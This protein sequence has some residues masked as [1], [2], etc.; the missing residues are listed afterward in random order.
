MLK[1]SHY[2]L[3]M[4]PRNAED[5]EADIQQGIRRGQDGFVL[6][7][8]A[9]STD[10]NYKA[11]ADLLF[12]AADKTSFG[13][14]WSLDM[15]GTLTAADIGAMVLGY[16]KRWSYIDIDDRPFVSTFRGEQQTA[17]W[18]S[19]TLAACGKPFFAPDF[20]LQRVGHHPT[21]AAQVGQI[22]APYLN[23]IDGV[24]YFGTAGLSSDISAANAAYVAWARSAGKWVM[25]GVSPGYSEQRP[26]TPDFG[27][28]YPIDPAGFEAQLASVMSLHPD[29]VEIVTENDYTEDSQ[30]GSVAGV[31]Q[32]HPYLQPGLKLT[33]HT[34][35]SDAARR[36]FG[37]C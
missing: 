8:G 27:L 16:R 18:W 21:T 25:C 10:P 5:A 35:Q 37:N 23:M 7:C 2:M 34:A 22:Y 1:L 9:W 6:N 24:F 19:N 11:R 14:A 30:I 28:S 12:D 31:Y 3:C 36:V 13:L 17:A 20:N 26:G 4:G 15:T 33:D 32:R 29:A